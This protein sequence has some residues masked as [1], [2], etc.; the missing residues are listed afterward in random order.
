MKAITIRKVQK[1]LTIL[2]EKKASI[3]LDGIIMLLEIAANPDGISIQVAADRHGIS[4]S[5]ASR[6]IAALEKWK[7]QGVK[8]LGLVTTEDDPSNRRFRIVK[9]NR[10]MER[11]MK[12]LDDALGE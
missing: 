5:A 8:G 1:L 4:Q 11:L 2:R 10:A 6:H 3:R 9:P 12:Q 7:K